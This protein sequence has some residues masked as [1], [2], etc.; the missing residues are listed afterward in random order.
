MPFVSQCSYYEY[1][2]LARFDHDQFYPEAH[3]ILKPGGCLAAWGYDLLSFPHKQA[4]SSLLNN[5]FHVTL[6]SYWHA[7]L[8]H[9]KQHY[10]G[11]SGRIGIYFPLQHT[12]HHS[13][14]DGCCTD[15]EP[16]AALFEVQH[17]QLAVDTT[18]TLSFLVRNTP[19]CAVGLLCRYPTTVPA[20][21]LFACSSY[22]HCMW[23]VGRA[24]FN[25]VCLQLISPEQATG[26]RPACSLQGSISPCST[27]IFS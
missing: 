2:D 16:D 19:A 17:V 20:Q 26:A 1:L 5:L 25:M 24:H 7:R 27:A 18:M 12:D 14:T 13:H 3:R 21:L 9:V 4:A 10:K 11:V 22:K 8:E 6:G 15:I 23:H